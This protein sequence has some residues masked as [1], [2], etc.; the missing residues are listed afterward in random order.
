MTSPH[1]ELQG[2]TLP[3]EAPGDMPR[4][5]WLQAGVQWVQVSREARPQ[6][7]C[8]GS[9]APWTVDLSAR[10]SSGGPAQRR[11]QMMVMTRQLGKEALQMDTLCTP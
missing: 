3:A 11:T 4:G 6:E 10:T 5:P 9:L 8:C 2:P 1:L 7:L